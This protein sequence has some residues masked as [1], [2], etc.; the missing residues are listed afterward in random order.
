MT[1]AEQTSNE[2]SRCLLSYLSYMCLETTKASETRIKRLLAAPKQQKII[3]IPCSG[4]QGCNT[5]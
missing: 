5:Q 4:N 3:S 2:T 1:I